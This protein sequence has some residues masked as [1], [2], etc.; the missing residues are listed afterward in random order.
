[1]LKR[2]RKIQ[3]IGKFV[4][5]QAPGCEFGIV[6]IIFGHNTQGKSTLT[7]ILR[8]IQTGNNDILIGRKSFSVTSDKKVEIDFEETGANDS[9]IFQNRV[10]NKT[11]SNILIFDSKFIADNIFEGEKITFDQQKKLNTII[12][13][14]KGQ[15]L[16]KEINDLQARSDEY[17]RQ[18]TENTK[19][20]S[21]HFPDFDFDKFK[22]IPKN[23]KIEDD[24]KDKNKGIKFELEKEEIKKT[25]KTHIHALSE[26]RYSIRDT[27]AKTLDIKQEE[28]ETHIKTHFSKD[29]NARTFLSEGVSFMKE[30]SADD[31]KRVCVFC[32]QKLE[33]KAESL[34]GLYLAFFKGGYV[35]LQKEIGGAI[36]YL[37]GVN[38]E[39]ILGK[40]ASDLK[41]KELD[42]GLSEIRISELANLK[43]EFEKELDKKR[44]LNYSINFETF[45]RL[46]AEVEQIKADLEELEKKK[47]NIPSPNPL[48][49]LEKEKGELEIIRKRYEP[50]WVRFCE[51]FKNIETEAEKV[52]RTRDE[53]RKELEAYS[54]SI[55]N[56]HKDTINKLCAE[57]GAEFEI[58]DFRPLKKLKGTDE[59]IFTI[60]FDNH[61][62]DIDNSDDKTPNFTNTLSESDKRLLAFSFFLSFISH[63]I[64][65]NKKI[66]LLDDPMSSFDTERR[67]KTVHLITDIAYKY[68]EAGGS[69][70]IV[71]PRQKIILT[72]EERF[73]KELKRLMPD[74]CTL[75][76]EKP[77]VSG[78]KG[79][80]INHADFVHDFP[81]DDISCRI[82]KIRDML[83]KKQFATPFDA[84]C[85]IVMEHIF[86]RKYCL[87]LKDE[88]AN[89]KGVRTFVNRLSALNVSDYSN[90]EKN[91]KFTRLCDD[92]NIELHDNSTSHS[93]GDKASILKDFF[94]CLKAI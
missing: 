47:I 86:K 41:A 68:T 51:D 73:A 64:E 90:E 2:I 75:K 6:T 65:L 61:K 19:E 29:Q 57:M 36:D 12:I 42:I 74:A 83:D 10:W 77:V 40:I 20:F 23:N 53:K 11:N 50:K 59:R 30:R 45:D 9:Y 24:I 14:K 70:Q 17:A 31:S 15:D 34:L 63:D 87:Q 82:E 88:I 1:M 4:D 32:G 72:H 71:K 85:R 94:E 28:I 8:S 54:A 62:V 91:K 3:N 44:D 76:I 38:V 55:F 33:D 58:E 80:Q 84:D 7:A 5:C 39:A 81:D 16:N 56:I 52:R 89:R 22:S 48:S 78:K 35:Q 25:I 27:F 92:L 60:K 93:A 66:I 26:I 79:S 67:R 46:R 13:G 21:R 37:K 43:K 49:D 18:K 69:E